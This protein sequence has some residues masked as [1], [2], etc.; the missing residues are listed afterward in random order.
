L[1]KSADHWFNL[2]D[3]VKDSVRRRRGS[4]DNQD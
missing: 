3:A 4:A 2:V 1:G